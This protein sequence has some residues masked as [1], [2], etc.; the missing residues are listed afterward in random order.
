VFKGHHIEIKNLSLALGILFLGL[1]SKE[2]FY[3]PAILEKFES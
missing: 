2:T 3:N 1:S